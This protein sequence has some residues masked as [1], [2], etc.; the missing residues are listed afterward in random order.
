MDL[1]LVAPIRF[2][3]GRIS[4]LVANTP[5]AVADD[6]PPNCRN[7]LRWQLGH[8]ITVT[9]RVAVG[10]SGAAVS[11]PEEW[12]RYFGPG[13]TVYNFD[14]GTPT[15]SD[16]VAALEASTEHMAATIPGLDLAAPLA[17]PFTPAAATLKIEFL[18]QAVAVAPLHDSAHMGMMRVYYR[19]LTGRSPDE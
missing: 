14:A 7:S 1:D 16:L 19:I 17:V 11:Y 5:A 9:E 8:I 18:W 10:L 6:V 12:L 4:G 3:R 2:V 13:T 15:W